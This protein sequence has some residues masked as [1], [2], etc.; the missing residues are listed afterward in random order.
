MIATTPHT[1]CISGILRNVKVEGGRLDSSRARRAVGSKH[2][3]VQRPG[4]SQP[5]LAVGEE[6]HVSVADRLASGR[7]LVNV[8]G[9]LL[10]TT[11]SGGLN[12]G[13]SLFVRVEQLQPQ[14]VLRMLNHVQGDEGQALDLLRMS[15]PHQTD[16]DSSLAALLEALGRITD[17]PG[18]EVPAS[19]AQLRALLTT[20]VPE[21]TQL[22][23][24][25]IAALVRATGLQYEAKLIDLDQLSPQ[26]LKTVA[27]TDVKGLLLQVLDD[28][29]AVS[30]RSDD[31]SPLTAHLSQI[32]RQQATNLL[33]QARGEPIQLQLPILDG[34]VL[35]AAYVSIGHDRESAR[36]N[37]EQE[38]R[39]EQSH[40]HLLFL[41]DLGGF[42]P[43]RI[44]AQLTEQSLKANFY[45]EETGA[46][47][48]LREEFPVFE[49]I[50]HALG[51]TQVQLSAKPYALLSPGKRQPFE[52]LTA[53]GGVPQ[54]MSLLD[55]KA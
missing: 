54:S 51:Y 6:L 13:D 43:T 2:A 42:G 20:L 55:V 53:A 39:G 32:E 17:A 30:K 27:E 9:T 26:A 50:L 12:V 5:H 19:V 31:L 21:G 25:H 35:T 14:V 24:E 23:A 15:L 7:Y 10:A 11:A 22:N 28:L 34:H 40:Y 49:E 44:D 36:E 48:F 52:A 46:D 4:Q 41:L 3:G 16:A 33:A 18:Y 29:L 1:S 47:T 8:R 37:G 45:V 38:G